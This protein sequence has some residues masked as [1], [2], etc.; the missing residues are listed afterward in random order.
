MKNVLAIVCGISLVGTALVGTALVGTACG[1]ANESVPLAPAVAREQIAPPATS[2][3]LTPA[4][5]S[6]VYRDLSTDTDIETEVTLHIDSPAAQPSTLLLG[7][8]AGACSQQRYDEGG[9]VSPTS[10]P[11]TG[12]VCYLGGAS[13]IAITRVGD[14]IIA[15]TQDQGDGVETDSRT[16]RERED[17]PG[18]W[19]ELGRIALPAAV[20]VQ[21]P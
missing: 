5:L 13:T 15:S 2:T 12:T 20:Q 18:A 19:R 21:V 7:R 17:P 4:A 8:F 10:N 14:Q 6:F 11:L 9:R 3:E 1:T 16:V